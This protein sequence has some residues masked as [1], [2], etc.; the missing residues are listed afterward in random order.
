MRLESEV[1][2]SAILEQHFVHGKWNIIKIFIKGELREII[3]RSREGL[4]T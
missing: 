4:H 1:R 2:R 3:V